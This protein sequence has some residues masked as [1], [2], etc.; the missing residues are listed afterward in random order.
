MSRNISRLGVLFGCIACCGVLALV[1]QGCRTAPPAIEAA[2]PV[3]EELPPGPPKL[4]LLKTLDAKGAFVRLEGKSLFVTMDLKRWKSAAKLDDQVKAG[5]WFDIGA[6]PAAP[7]LVADAALPAGWDVAVIGKHAVVCDYTR[8]LAIYEVKGKQWQ[9]AAK[10][11]MP[12]LTE[13]IVVRDRLAYIANHTVGLTIVDV[14]TPA[15]PVL[16]SNINPKIDCDALGLWGDYAALYGHHESRLVFVDVSDP[17]KPQQVGVY[18]HDAKTF[19]QGEVCVDKGMV[20][21]TAKN[22]LVI[23]DATDP[24]AAKLVKVVDMKFVSDVKVRDGYAFVSSRDG[25]KVLDVRDP[26]DPVELLTYRCN[27]SEL[28]VEVVGTSYYIYAADRR[29]GLKVFRF[30]PGRG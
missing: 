19:T 18:Q 13:N 10:L 23:V 15:K 2:P 9:P 8:T 27:A 20:Y 14:S 4:E 5:Y 21:C 29:T 30:Q 7:A 11:K 25:L 16:I 6:D 26:A 24:A 1:A 12:G 17:A 28:C 3:A 22:G